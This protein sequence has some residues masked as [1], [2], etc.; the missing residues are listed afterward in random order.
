MSTPD[1][2][3]AWLEAKAKKY[4]EDAEVFTS[5]RSRDLQVGGLTAEQWATVYRAVA[6]ELRECAREAAEQRPRRWWRRG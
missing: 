1:R 5:A 6:Y 4:A 3:V 2:H